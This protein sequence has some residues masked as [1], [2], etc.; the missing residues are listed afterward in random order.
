MASR[1]DNMTQKLSDMQIVLQRQAAGAP[2]GTPL[3]PETIDKLLKII[4]NVTQQV[5]V[6]QK[7]LGAPAMPGAL[8]LPPSGSCGHPCN[9]S[10]S[11]SHCSASAAAPAPARRPAPAPALRL[12]LRKPAY[13]RRQQLT[14]T[15][16]GRQIDWRHRRGLIGFGEKNPDQIRNPEF[17][18]SIRLLYPG[19]PLIQSASWKMKKVFSNR[20]HFVGHGRDRRQRRF[21]GQPYSS[22]TPLPM[23]VPGV[24]MPLDD[25]DA[26][27]HFEWGLR[28]PRR[29]PHRT[30]HLK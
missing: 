19:R 16:G 25:S 22:G 17:F 26:A 1:L 27:L 8:R 29:R 6:L 24:P 4:G 30:P 14:G 5:D 3:T 15:C 23:R 18:P 28:P 11:G 20:V 21:S 2:A 7:S 10:G 12:F 13:N 9:A